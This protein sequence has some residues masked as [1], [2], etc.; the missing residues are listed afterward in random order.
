V[1]GRGSAIAPKMP[2]NRQGYVVVER[3]G[4]GLF[5]V[6][7]QLRQNLQDYARLYFQLTRQLIDTDLTQMFR[8]LSQ[9]RQHINQI[10]LAPL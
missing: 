9:Q 10:K 2:P 7:A 6:E 8:S 5:F 1:R 4:V 3:T